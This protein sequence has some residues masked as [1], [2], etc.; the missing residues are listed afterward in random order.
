MTAETCPHYLVFASEA[1]PPGATQYKCAPPLRVGQNRQNLLT[2]L[3]EGNASVLVCRDQ[4]AV[5]TGS[6]GVETALGC[7]CWQ[8]I[9]HPCR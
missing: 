9:A 4:A 1:V 8:W 5:V 3:A 2:A 6:E 7:Y